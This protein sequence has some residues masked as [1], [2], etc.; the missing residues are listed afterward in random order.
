[1]LKNEGEEAS[2]SSFPDIEW[3]IIGNFFEGSFFQPSKARI[4]FLLPQD[5]RSFM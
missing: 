3:K 2:R 1:M 5:S 4:M